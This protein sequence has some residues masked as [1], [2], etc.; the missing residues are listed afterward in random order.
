MTRYLV[1]GA[2]LMLPGTVFSPEIGEFG[3]GKVFAV[4]TPGNPH[5]LAIGEAEMSSAGVA[6]AGGKGKFLRITNVYRD[7]LWDVAASQ[8]SRPRLTPNEGYL[9]D[10]VVPLGGYDLLEED[11][12][13]AEEDEEG[14][15]EDKG[16]EEEG[17]ERGSGGVGSVGDGKKYIDAKDR[18][19]V[20]D[21]ER[22]STEGVKAAL[23]DLDLRGEDEDD[24]EEEEEEEEEARQQQRRQLT[25]TEMDDLIDRSVLQALRGGGGGGGGL[26]D[27]S[28]PLLGSVFW[29]QYVV[30]SRPAANGATPL[31][32]KRS[33][34][35]KLSKLLQAKAKRGWLTV[36]E[37]KHTKE[38]MLTSVNRKHADVASHRS[39]ETAASAADVAAAAAAT[40][41]AA[42]PDFYRG[43]AAA[44]ATA[45]N[46][47][48]PP[49]P[50]VLDEMLKPAVALQGVFAALDAER[51]PYHDA[52]YPPAV[53][54][55][56][57]WAYV[58]AAGL[59]NG[60]PSRGHVMLDPTLCD[61]LFKGVLKKGDV[62][63]THML[64]SDVNAAWLNRFHPQTRVSRGGREYVKKGALAPVKVESD[65]RGGDR[66]VT[67]VAGFETYLIDPDELSATLSTKLA[68]ACATAEL[69]GANNKGKM[70]V[71]AQGNAVEKVT[72]ILAEHYSVPSRLVHSHDKLKG[73]G[74]NK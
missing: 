65:R 11:E 72:R 26:K 24:D 49:P 60:A 71:V 50:L 42:I 43:A 70:E 1:G 19:D 10:A 69:E 73:K 27:K 55:D 53:A 59:E 14:A 58:S 54:K 57:V 36:K 41:A 18:D 4:A 56:V 20:V 16:A 63:P 28:L 12:E 34:H 38:M 74:K 40:A 7:A 46:D 44:A 6:S 61:A 62:Y 32:V 9:Q 47:G 17:A 3:R 37:D 67:R 35:K 52:L 45:T 31:D 5:P 30:P 22:A 48:G 25:A 33:S 39:H 68:T 2:D 8:P 23:N 13:G 66:R 51:F 21:G 29:A 64:K 15:E